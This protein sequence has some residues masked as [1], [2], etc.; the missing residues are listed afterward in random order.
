MFGLV[1]SDEALGSS[2]DSRAEPFFLVSCLH[3]DVT[4]PGDYEG[5]G[6][7]GFRVWT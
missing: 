1:H 7:D 4:V 2:H 5:E 3:T 6:R